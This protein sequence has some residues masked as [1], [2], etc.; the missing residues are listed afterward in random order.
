MGT[1]LRK[2][3]PPYS[4]KFETFDSLTTKDPFKFLGLFFPLFI[5]HKLPNFKLLGYIYTTVSFSQ[6]Y[7]PNF[8][9]SLESKF[10]TDL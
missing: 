10:S 9:L 5:G 2:Y 8:D 3:R 1:L 4:A 6:L 7:S